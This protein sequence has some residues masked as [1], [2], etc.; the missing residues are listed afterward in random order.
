MG[1]TLRRSR[2]KK[3]IKGAKMIPLAQMPIKKSSEKSKRESSTQFNNSESQQHNTKNQSPIIA[4][5]PSSPSNSSVRSSLRSQRLLNLLRR[6]RNKMEDS[7]R[8]SLSTKT[9]REKAVLAHS[10]KRAINS[11]SISDSSK[12]L[13]SSSINSSSSRRSG[14]FNSQAC[15]LSTS[16]SSAKSMLKRRL[17]KR[18]SMSQEVG[19]SGFD[20]RLPESVT[21]ID[22]DMKCA[23]GWEADKLKSNV[24]NER[25]RREVEEWVDRMLEKGVKGLLN[26]FAELRTKTNP[27]ARLYQHFTHNEPFGRN[28]YKDVFCLDES[29]I[30]LHDH[31][32]GNDY[33]HA[34]YVS[35]PLMSNRFICTQVRTA[36][37]P[38]CVHCSAGIGR[39]GSVVTIAYIIECFLTNSRFE[40]LAEILQLLRQQ[41]AGIVQTAMQYLYVHRIM[42]IYFADMRL[43]S[44]SDRLNKFIR[45]YDELVST[46]Q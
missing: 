18:N 4:D 44:A 8:K 31:P 41:R 45:E 23:P 46:V 3:K 24:I 35:T 10:N 22:S 25:M 15:D 29:R 32:N 37:R 2:Q 12:S 16:Q 40:D 30:V 17:A 11:P 39:T 14:R 5:T 27:S 43:I 42:L 26:E 21:T 19:Q 6:K 34:N 13:Q 9:S 38:I 7:S 28:R 33:I 36:K 20:Q 1:N